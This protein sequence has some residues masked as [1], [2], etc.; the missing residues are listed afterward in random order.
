[1]SDETAKKA[2]Q[3][4]EAA[5]PEQTEAAPAPESPPTEVQI[6]AGLEA[7]V[8]EL[9]DR[10]L[11]ALAE[12]ENVRR[13]AE[14]DRKDAETFG[15]TRLARDLLSVHDNL[16]RALAH[17][18]EALRANAQA[19]IEGVE[20]TQR[21]LLNAF[22]KHKIEKVTPAP[23]EKFDPHRHQAMFEAPIPGA[24]PGSVIDVMEAGFTIAGR[25]LRPA[26]V[27]VARAVPQ[28]PAESAAGT[29]SAK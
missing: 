14:R 19:F 26:K 12:T 23:G 7:E 1:M 17:V 8:A 25:L 2:D 28:A 22:A 5:A 11:R 21:E 20:L 15:G 6:I 27:G 10:L 16:D 13:R 29:D 9:R 18:D 4:T 24:Q 3:G